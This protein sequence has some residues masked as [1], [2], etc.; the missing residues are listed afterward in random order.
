MILLRL[1]CVA[2]VVAAA[3]CA[4]VGIRT[5]GHQP[6]TVIIGQPTPTPVPPTAPT[7]APSVVP[8]K[9]EFDDPPQR[10]GTRRVR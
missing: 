8:G 7:P 6:I 4:S 5:M 9:L 2:L 3:G 10:I 1:L